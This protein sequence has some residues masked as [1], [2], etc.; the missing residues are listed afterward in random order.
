MPAVNICLF[1]LF[2]LISLN[3]S[4]KTYKCVD[5]DGNIIYSQTACKS[6]QKT[7]K[8][9]GSK[10]SNSSAI[11]DSEGSVDFDVC[12]LASKFA[13]TV[14]NSMRSGVD[15]PKTFDR[16]GG[17]NSVSKSV[18]GIVNYVYTYADAEDVP[19]SKIGSLT[20]VKCNAQSFGKLACEDLPEKF[21]VGANSCDEDERE[22]AE[23]V[24]KQQDRSLQLSQPQQELTE[25]EK[26]EMERKKKREQK[27]EEEERIEECKERYDSQLESVRVSLRNASNSSTKNSLR[28]ERKQLQ[29]D[30]YSECR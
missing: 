29:K 30:R 8:V 16:Y 10:S 18:I 3:A 24:N 20:A 12:G 28:A 14:A 25:K 21:T 6:N 11:S 2:A 5:E 9:M 1:L 27:E 19:V 7:D 22:Q 4:A 17:I 26:A 15:A 13:I 23:L